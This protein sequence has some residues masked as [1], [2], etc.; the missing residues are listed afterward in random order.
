MI[1]R[2]ISFRKRDI[3]Y[4]SLLKSWQLYVTTRETPHKNIFNMAA[5]VIDDISSDSGIF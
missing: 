5:T 4:I 1:R 2:S 3:S